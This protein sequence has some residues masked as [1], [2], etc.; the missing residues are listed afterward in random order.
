MR[1][2]IRRS[3]FAAGSIVASLSL[4]STAFGQQASPAT[5]GST[6]QMQPA[7]LK[8]W[9]SIRSSVLSNDGKWFAYV[10]APNEGDA[11]VVIRSTGTDNKEWTFPIGSSDAWRGGGGGRGGP[12]GDATAGPLSISADSR[13]AAFMV[14]PPSSNGRAGRTGGAGRGGRGGGA[15]TTQDATQAA[16]PANKLA[17]VNLSTGEKKEFDRVRRYAFN[18]DK[19]SWLA[20]Q[21]PPE[22][23]AAAT[24]NAAGGARGGAAP[25]GGNAPA[26]GRVEGTDLLLYNLSNGEAVNVG[27]VA[28]FGFD[29]TGD[30]LAYT[31]DARD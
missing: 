13:W 30:W 5:A 7:D 15:P 9:K 10:L 22:A 14:Y 28:E 29:D 2:A 25:A 21:A 3:L 6:K 23:S 31:I 8:A 27:N 16:P 1:V 4:V 17:L 20:I 24:G 19:P 12:P 26:A 11:S 18:G